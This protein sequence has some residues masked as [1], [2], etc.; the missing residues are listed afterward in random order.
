MIVSAIALLVPLPIS[1]RA[2][3]AIGDMVHAPLFGFLTLVSF[4]FMNRLRPL[5]SN[6]SI[7]PVVVRSLVCGIGVFVLGV[8]SEVAQSVSGRSAA[9]HDAFANSSGIFA[10]VCLRIT[11]FLAKRGELSRFTSLAIFALALVPVAMSWWN[12]VATLYDIY[13]S[14]REFPL[15]SSSERQ[16]ELQRWHFA[17]SSGERSPHHIDHGTYSLRVDYQPGAH[18]T[19]TLFDFHRD[20]SMMEKLMMTVTLSSH[21]LQESATVAIQ[22]IDA[23]HNPDF[24]NIYRRQWRLQRNLKTTIELACS[25]FQDSSGRSLDLRRIRYLDV[26]LANPEQETTL[27]IDNI[28][29]VPKQF[30]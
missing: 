15:L 19:A 22:V 10:V 12:P 6:D 14:Q 28:R 20:W 13:Q 11:F 16:A 1:G 3:P 4:L 5:V 25:S 29:L 7:R 8:A 2:A 23:D 18:P 26:Q 17:G 27:F 24:T 9:I 21:H 30:D